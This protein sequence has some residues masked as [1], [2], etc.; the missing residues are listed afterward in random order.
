MGR[1]LMRITPSI[2]A[3]AREYFQL[4]RENRLPPIH[5]A[6][7]FPISPEAVL[8]IWESARFDLRR[9]SNAADFELCRVIVFK[10]GGYA[11]EFVPVNVPQDQPSLF[12]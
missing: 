1:Q 3:V 10:D 5:I 8:E 9:R 4:K 11:A 7:C 6:Q 2:V 12:D